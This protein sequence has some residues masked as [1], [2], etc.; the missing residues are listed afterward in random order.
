[1]VPLRPRDPSRRWRARRPP[2]SHPRAWGIAA[3][4][5]LFR[6]LRLAL[7]RQAHLGPQDAQRCDQMVEIGICVER[8]RGEAQALATAWHGGVVYRL[9]VD[10]E[11]IEQRV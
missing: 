8:G 9:H 2:Q 7:E 10:G 6:G 4:G 5:D 3:A 11:A 1:M